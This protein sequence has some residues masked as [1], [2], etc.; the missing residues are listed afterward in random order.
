MK[1]H[2]DFIDP[3]ASETENAFMA[4]AI[5]NIKEVKTKRRLI[6]SVLSLN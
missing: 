5:P 3:F 6:I 2:I 4:N 1:L